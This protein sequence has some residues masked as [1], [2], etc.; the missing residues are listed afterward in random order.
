MITRQN[1]S[2]LDLVVAI[3]LM[4]LAQS[5][6]GVTIDVCIVKKSGD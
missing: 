3:D 5:M 4:P 1:V 2:A 6:H